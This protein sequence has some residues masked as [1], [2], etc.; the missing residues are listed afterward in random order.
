MKTA[1]TVLLVCAFA[2][3]VGC[4][5]MNATGCAAMDATAKAATQAADGAKNA[6]NA[7]ASVGVPYAG[8]AAM[9]IAGVSWMATTYL[10]IRN[11]KLVVAAKQIVPAV[12][13]LLTRVPAPV[14]DKWKAEQAVSQ[15]PATKAIVAASKAPDVKPDV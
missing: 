2:I 1:A 7:A 14:A 13:D 3:I 9:A 6:A 8:F 11:S 4:L 12:D 10:K 15:L 5:V